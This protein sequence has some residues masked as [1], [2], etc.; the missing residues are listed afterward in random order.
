MARN[1]N[2]ISIEIF[3]QKS[4]HVLKSDMKSYVTVKPR[5]CQIKADTA[6]YTL[7]RKKSNSDLR[8][9]NTALNFFHLA[10]TVWKKGNVQRYKENIF[11]PWR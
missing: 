7:Q 5:L 8:L 1:F 6:V 9:R 4:V 2:N 10:S 11:S 3:F